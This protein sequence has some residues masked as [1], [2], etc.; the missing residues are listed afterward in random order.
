MPLIIAT[1]AFTTG[2]SLL[3]RVRARRRPHEFLAVAGSR[4]HRRCGMLFAAT[5]TAVLVLGMGAPRIASLVVLGGI[6]FLTIPM[7]FAGLHGRAWSASSVVP[8]LFCNG[9]AVQAAL[10]VLQRNSG[11]WLVVLT[12]ILVLTVAVEVFV[13]TS[14][15]TPRIAPMRPARRRP[16][17]PLDAS[18]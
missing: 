15:V 2:F 3:T 17:L 11:I 6:V 14:G 10:A 13:L 7:S 1:M 8:A 4:A 16:G 18:A 5:A 9:L 12:W